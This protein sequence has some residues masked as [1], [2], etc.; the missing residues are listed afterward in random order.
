MESE[1]PEVKKQIIEQDGSNRNSADESIDN[2]RQSYEEED[3]LVLHQR[4]ME[5][6]EKQGRRIHPRNKRKIIR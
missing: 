4:L 3:T 2:S 5:I 1:K 6:D